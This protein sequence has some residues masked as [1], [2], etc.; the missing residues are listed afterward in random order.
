MT[1]PETVTGYTVPGDQP[2]TVT[3]K[4]RNWQGFHG[5]ELFAAGDYF[6]LVGQ[7][8]AGP[9]TFRAYGTGLGLDLQPVALEAD[10]DSREEAVQ[11]LLDG[12]LTARAES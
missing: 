8:G 1:G 4:P 5:W 12:Y 2:I 9:Y 7:Y 10:F 11:W 3:L 6:G